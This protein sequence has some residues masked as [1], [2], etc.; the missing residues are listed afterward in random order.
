MIPVRRNLALFL[1]NSLPLVAKM[2]L[3]DL[4]PANLVLLDNK[5]ADISRKQAWRNSVWSLHIKPLV[6]S[7]PEDMSK[8][9]VGMML[10]VEIFDALNPFLP[11]SCTSRRFAPNDIVCSFVCMSTRLAQ[12]IGTLDSVLMMKRW[13]GFMEKLSEMNLTGE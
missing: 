6:H 3:Q 13:Q 9:W 5:T 1:L 10:D 11:P 7:L 8:Q 4:P 12:A 2:T